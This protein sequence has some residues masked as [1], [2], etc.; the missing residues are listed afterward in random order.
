MIKYR[1][2]KEVHLEISTKCNARCPWCIRNFW[3]YPY[4]DGYPEVNLSID[5]CKKIF[6][7]EFVQQLNKLYIN[8]NFGDVVMNP[9]SLE[10]V[11]YFRA[12]NSTLEI[13]I[14][15]NA[16]ARNKDFWQGLAKANAGIHFCIDG[17]EDTHSL[18]R[19]NT[20]YNLILKNA[21]S[22][23]SAGGNA[24]WIMNVFEHNKHQI[25]TCRELAK[26]LGFKKF[27]ARNDGRDTG[28]VFDVDGNLTHTLGQYTGDTDFKVMFYKKKTDTVMLE[29][30]ID[31]RVPKGEINCSA[32]KHKS[33]YVAANG[34]VSPCCYTGAYPK[35]FGHGQYHQAAN[36]QLAPLATQNNA[37]LHGLE[38]SIEW[39]NAVQTSWKNST[40]E[41]GRLLICDD[42][43]GIE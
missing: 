21:E 13:D 42:V 25:D 3:G 31:S 22:F 40:F 28:P 41:S 23:I 39:F 5:D 7:T 30:V 8:G 34:E 4:N 27:V 14:S 43:C 6:T 38:K 33:I 9:D 36:S 24:I 37:I 11:N 16:S 12:H 1:T 18:Y 10:I 29:D 2:I 35:T 20:S 15:T 17:L 19:Q 32:K 26:S